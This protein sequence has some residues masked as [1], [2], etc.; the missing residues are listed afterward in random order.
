M[1]ERNRVAQL[2]D[3]LEAVVSSHG[4]FLEDLALRRRGRD[5]VLLITLDLADGPGALGSDQLGE[6]SR[7][8]SARLDELDLIPGAYTLEIS[9]P[10]TNR[11][12]TT[13]RHFRRATGRLVR[14]EVR[15][16][17]TIATVIGRVQEA[18][19]ERVVLVP[20][21]AEPQSMTYRDIV[22]AAVEVELRRGEDER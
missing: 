14:A 8:L 21:G 11:P 10:G 4:L 15:Q 2:R 18:D 17:E 6:V 13:P 9:T 3:G 5:Q 16:G 20:L 1:S 7:D 19:E 12:L 22:S